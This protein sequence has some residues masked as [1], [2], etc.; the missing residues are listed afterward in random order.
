MSLRDAIASLAQGGPYTVT[1]TA[2]GTREKGHYTPG[3]ETTFDIVASVQPTDGAELHD[4]AEGQ[5]TDEVRVIYTVTELRTRTPAGEPDRI[6]LEG[7]ED[8]WIVIKVQRFDAFGGTHYR[9][10]AARVEHP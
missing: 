10:W 2:T 5:R 6:E 3:S 8:P 9:A 1:R 4:L 7:S